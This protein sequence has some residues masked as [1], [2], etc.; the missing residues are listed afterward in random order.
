MSL[1]LAAAGFEVLGVE[2]DALACKTHEREV[3][4]VVCGD[5]RKFS[6]QGPADLVAGGSPCQEYSKTGPKRGLHS[7]RGTLFR[8]LIRVGDEADARVLLL[9]NVPDILTTEAF[10]GT[11]E[12]IVDVVVRELREHG[13]ASKHRILNAMDY[14]VPQ[15][16]R[17][18]FIFASR[19]PDLMRA[20]SFP[21][22]SHG[23]KGP[24]PYVTVREATGIG[25][26][27][28][29]PT[30]TATEWK[31]ARQP[32]SRG[33]KGST[34]RSRERM[35]AALGVPIDAPSS[36]QWQ[37]LQGF[38][39]GMRFVGTKAQRITQIGNAVAPPVAMALGLAIRE[40]LETVG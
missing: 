12:M 23:P 34:R 16:R 31:A 25:F 39:E 18:L 2:I 22:P 17:R 33:G 14:G 24:L 30:V 5:V 6:P 20:F 27:E 38:P 21:E 10:V 28:V 37:A 29:A 36:E 9:E 7:D 13:Y 1:G 32:G 3:G 4:P 15:F 35:S 11:D 19:E 40:A 26:D 8:E